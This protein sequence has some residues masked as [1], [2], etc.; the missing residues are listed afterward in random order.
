MRVRSSLIRSGGSCGGTVHICDALVDHFLD[1]I[2]PNWKIEKLA[3]K[4]EKRHFKDVIGKIGVTEKS[5][6]YELQEGLT[7]T[8]TSMCS[9]PAVHLSFIG[10]INTVI[11]ATDL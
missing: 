2:R 8:G 10:T 4:N 7:T 5:H 3:G 11:K 9:L 1:E 6:F